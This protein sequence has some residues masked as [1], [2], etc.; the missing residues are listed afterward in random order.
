MIISDFS[1]ALS[2]FTKLLAG[3]RKKRHGKSTFFIVNP[4]MIVNH[5]RDFKGNQISFMIKDHCMSRC[6]FL[7]LY[8]FKSMISVGIIDF[9]FII[10]V[11]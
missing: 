6:G 10:A 5:L 7:K 3:V 1:A 9:V 11:R 8:P 4:Q 2:C